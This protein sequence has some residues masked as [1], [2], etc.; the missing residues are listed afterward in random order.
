MCSTTHI[1]YIALCYC[2]AARTDDDDG[3][4]LHNSR[5]RAEPLMDKSWTNTELQKRLRPLAEG[6]DK[7]V[8][9]M[10]WQIVPAGGHVTVPAHHATVPSEPFRR[11]SEQG[12]E[13]TKASEPPE[14]PPAP[15]APE[16]A[17][18]PQPTADEPAEVK[19][20]TPPPVDLLDDAGDDEETESATEASGPD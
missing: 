14:A 13:P 4:V 10:H 15:P 18:E 7:D 8:Q 1:L 9:S 6:G 12:V 17:A 3:N 19:P 2:I 5:W 11:I 16:A 20:P